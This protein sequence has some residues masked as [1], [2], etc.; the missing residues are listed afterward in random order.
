VRRTKLLV[1]GA[2]IATLALSAG[3]AVAKPLSKKEWQKQGNAICKSVN[4]SI[5]E[6]GSTV[7]AGLGK[8]EEPSAEQ[9]A[10]FAAGFVPLIRAAVPSIEALEAPKSL[11]SQIKKFTTQT[12]ADL[13]KVEADPS[14][15]SGS[16]DPFVKSNK[17]AKKLGLKACA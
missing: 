6:L 3:V 16:T 12:E 8:N 13:A 1:A 15:L 2:V 14:L 10:A 7:F 4:T 17:I 5:D 9:T 11:Q